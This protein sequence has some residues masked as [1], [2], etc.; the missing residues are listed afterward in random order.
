MGISSV[1]K[2][3][4]VLLTWCTNLDSLDAEHGVERHAGL[5]KRNG[6]NYI[7]ETVMHIQ[8]WVQGGRFYIN[9]ALDNVRTL[10][11]HY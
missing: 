1:L 8:P 3:M 10:A 4:C 9:S 6:L 7:S 5:V 2:G 11:V